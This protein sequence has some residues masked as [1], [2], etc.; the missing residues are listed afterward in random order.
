VIHYREHAAQEKQIAGLGCLDVV[1]ERRG[2]AG[3]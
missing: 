2:A 3:S 1:A